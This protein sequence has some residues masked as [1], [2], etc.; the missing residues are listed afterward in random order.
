MVESER[1][2]KIYINGLGCISP[3]ESLNNLPLP[4]EPLCIEGNRLKTIDP[5]YKEFVPPE[6]V[7]RMG[8]IIKMGVAAGK[9]A[10]AD[11]GIEKPEMIITGT[12]LGCIQDTEKFL[13]NM[14][15]NH[16]EFLTPTS[17]IQ[18]THNTVSAQIALLTKCHGT[19]FTYVHRGASFESAILDSI[20]RIEQAETSQ[21]LLGA[22]DEITNDS[23]VIQERLGFW[24]RD[25]ISSCQVIQQPGRGSVAGEG[26]AFFVLETAPRD[27]TYAILH[28]TSMLS[29]PAS[30]EEILHWINRFL[31][32]HK[33]NS[34]NISLLLS[35][36]NGNTS[37][38]TGMDIILSQVFRDI[39]LGYFKHLCGEYM[40]ATGFATWLAACMLKA[41]HVPSYVGMQP[42]DNL[43]NILI[44][45][46][47]Q[48][49]N[50]TLILLSKS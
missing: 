39:P 23:F 14:I 36:K 12:G 31:Q 24:R 27:S 28:D 40:T 34:G 18:S 9:T 37:H 19:N 16:E 11:A 45:N 48:D 15:R 7:R 50:H 49:I 41:Q 6:M 30:Q 4:A 17:F 13:G 46:N 8:R 21:I 25:P 43:D 22:A 26:A 2:K 1:N 47:Y 20:L 33:L 5:N 3:Q 10:L 35:G 29:G 44:Y 42:I 38:D 32:N